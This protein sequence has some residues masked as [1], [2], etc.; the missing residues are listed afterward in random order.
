MLHPAAPMKLSAYRQY[1]LILCARISADIRYQAVVDMGAYER[2]EFC[3][4]DDLGQALK[5][6]LNLDCYID[7]LDFGI[8]CGNWLKYVGPD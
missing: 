5:G 4:D 1:A 2:Y 6:D 3:G 8:M 7:L